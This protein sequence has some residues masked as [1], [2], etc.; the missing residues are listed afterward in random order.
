MINLK[1]A[2]FMGDGMGALLLLMI[3]FS[4][5]RNRKGRDFTQKMFF[6]CV[7][8]TG[9]ECLIDIMSYAVDGA[10]F[11]GARTLNYLSNTFLAIGLTLL[12]YLWTVYVRHKTGI[13]EKEGL[14]R[15]EKRLLLPVAAVAVI[16]IVNLF[17]PIVFIINEQNQYTRIVGSVFLLGS[18]FHGAAAMRN[19]RNYQFFPVFYF[20]IFT[21]SGVVLQMLFYGISLIYSFSAI[22]LVGVY[23]EIQKEYSYVDPLSGAYNRQYMNVYLYAL[24]REYQESESKRMNTTL[25]CLLLDVDGFKKINDTYGHLAGD[26]AIRDIGGILR[27]SAPEK[28]VCARYGGDEFV[29]IL[30]VKDIHELDEVTERIQTRRRALNATGVNPYQLHF[31]IGRTEYNPEEDT[32]DILLKRLDNLMYIEKRKRHAKRDAMEAG[33]KKDS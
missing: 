17:T 10:S 7:G 27:A 5:R 32:P 15:T 4:G 19:S 31:S 26:Q 18:S 12:C 25:A 21:F 29:M 11:A 1:S 20:E 6:R 22:A 33:Q 24:C 3:I 16:Y 23:F 13:T 2:N 28:A 30:E 9:I 14:D 8:F